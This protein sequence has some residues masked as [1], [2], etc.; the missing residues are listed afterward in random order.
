MD[1]R[2]SLPGPAGLYRGYLSTV[3]R[4][5]PFSFIQFPIWE[6]LKKRYSARKEK[7]IQPHESAICGAVAGKV[8][9]SFTDDLMQTL[10]GD[11]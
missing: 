2:F 1:R 9:L 4:E 11:S 6:E 5:I 8:T 10:T 7:P 3:V